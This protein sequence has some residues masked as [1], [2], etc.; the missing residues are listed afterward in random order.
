[1]PDGVLQ[2]DGTGDY[3]SVAH[4]NAL[5]F[6]TGQ[7][8]TLETWVNLNDVTTL[9]TLIDKSTPG[10]DA[11]Y[12]LEVVNGEVDFWSPET[13]NVDVNFSISTD[14][15]T[16]FAELGLLGV[17]FSEEA[18]GFN[19]GGGLLAA[20]CEKV[21]GLRWAISWYTRCSCELCDHSRGYAL[22]L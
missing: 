5:S 1:M 2:L 16:Q 21:K 12:R 18:G 11:N 15:W 14:T 8:F 22:L 6:G 9:Q 7:S 17:P 4:N 20:G 10:D 19:G 13:G 3:I